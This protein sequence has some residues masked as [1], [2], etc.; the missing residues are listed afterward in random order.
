MTLAD[1]S[2]TRK[3][4]KNKKKKGREQNGGGGASSMSNEPEVVQN[5]TTDLSADVTLP[6][7]QDLS[8]AETTC[9]TT[10]T[11]TTTAP[12]AAPDKEDDEDAF[13]DFLLET[14]PAIV[15]CPISHALFR[16]PITA[17][18]TH[19]YELEKL[20]EWIETCA[21]KGNPLTS[22]A[23]GAVMASV[24]LKSQV[25]RSLVMEHIEKKTQEWKEMGRGK[26]KG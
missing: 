3:K 12:A 7:L 17:Q 26:K 5:E 19:T 21:R 23:T 2:S 22:P 15:I 4:N 20:E 9:T 16:E 13:Q 14:A 8:I 10:T 24:Y 18:D 11:A 25:A 6:A 1:S